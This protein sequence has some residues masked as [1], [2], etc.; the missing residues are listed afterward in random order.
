MHHLSLSRT[1][2]MA[3]GMGVD[4]GLRRNANGGRRRPA[5]PSDAR[6]SSFRWRQHLSDTASSGGCYGTP[7]TGIRR[8]AQT[9]GPYA[10]AGSVTG[11]VLREPDPLVVV[12][13]D[14]GLERDS[15]VKAVLRGFA[16]LRAGP[17]A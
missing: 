8:W 13:E 2:P 14:E 6:R 3:G 9:A 10:V 17:L 12:V 7:T 5:A 16:Q 11:R 15:A 1:S 4:N